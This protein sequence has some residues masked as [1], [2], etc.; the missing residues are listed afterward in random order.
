MATK[1]IV[2]TEDSLGRCFNCGKK[3]PSKE[4]Y[5]FYCSKKCDDNDQAR[6][7]AMVEKGLHPMTIA[8]KAF[9]KISQK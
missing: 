3:F 2:F 5:D 4:M 6:I 1:E 9:K 8:E 7:K